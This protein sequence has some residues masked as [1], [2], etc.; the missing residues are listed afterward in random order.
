[1][2]NNRRKP[3]DADVSGLYINLSKKVVKYSSKIDIYSVFVNFEYQFIR[4][5]HI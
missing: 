2:S 4:K 5:I 3:A 1:M